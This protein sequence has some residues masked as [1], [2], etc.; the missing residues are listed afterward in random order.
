M[1]RFLLLFAVMF[2]MGP[3][4][5]SQA[6]S[7]STA[8]NRRY[9]AVKTTVL[10]SSTGFFASDLKN[11]SQGDEVSLIRESGKWAEVRSGNQTGWVAVSS[12][13]TR[14]VVASASSATASEVAMAGKG[15]SAETEVEY[16]KGGL[17]YF[18]VDSM[19]QINIPANELLGF[20]TDGHLKKGE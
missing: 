18:A 2:S 20:I 16:R 10:K 5:F 12:L 13:S 9:V 11:L 8:A 14:R 6:A 1:R 4:L 7:S 19:E 3:L 15:F 17:N